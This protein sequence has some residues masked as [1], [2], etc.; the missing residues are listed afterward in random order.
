M[1]KI[2]LSFQE[3]DNDIEILKIEKEIKYHRMILSIENTIISA[4]PANIISRSLKLF[5]NFFSGNA[6]NIILK[7]TPYII[8][9]IL[10][11]K[12]SI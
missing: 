1:K 10:K 12:R 9:W 3:I 7:L 4:N 2:Y 6:G 5:L 8:E 11:K